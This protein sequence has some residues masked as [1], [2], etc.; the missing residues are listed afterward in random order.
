MKKFYFLVIAGILFPL[1]IQSQGRDQSDGMIPEKAPAFM[2]YADDVI[3][4]ENPAENQR[5]ACISVAFNGWLYAAHLTRV[6][7]SQAVIVYRS[8]DQ[9]GTWDLWWSL[10]FVTTVQVNA[11]DI[12]VCGNTEEDLM[13]FLAGTHYYDVSDKY[14]TWV[15]S[16]EGDQ[17]SEETQPVLMEFDYPVRDIAIVSDYKFPSAGAAPYSVGVLFPESTDVVDVLHFL[18]SADGG[19]SFTYDRTL[20]TSWFIKNVSAAYGRCNSYPSGRYFLAWDEFQYP[21]N[22]LGRIFWSYTDPGFSS[23][24]VSAVRLDIL[25]P[26]LE[27]LCKNPVISSQF[28]AY[29]NSLGN[30]TTVILFERAWEGSATDY[31]VLGYYNKESVWTNAWDFTSISNDGLNAIQPDINF[32]PAYGNF[33]VTYLDS[34]NQALPYYVQY[35]EMETPINWIPI[36]YAYNDNA[37]GLV[38]PYPKVEIN[39]VEVQT[40]HLWTREGVGGNGITMFDAEYNFVGLAE[41]PA[42]VGLQARVYPNPCTDRIKISYYL[43]GAGHVTLQISDLTGRQVM[44]LQDILAAKGLQEIE[45]STAALEQGCYQY[46]IQAAALKSQGK[47]TVLNRP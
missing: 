8:I 41:P 43:A 6:G 34:T 5:H 22:R 24:L 31:D 13:V 9:G 38:A 36:S 32:D 1:L 42:P 26:A 20:A 45:I 19:V 7:T 44:C 28:T 4:L 10:G 37:S 2:R 3:I 11:L 33:L 16:F 29:D 30:L 23:E 15:Y 39:P 18:V 21:G 46:V 17:Y 14:Y 25:S 27:D 12:V 47:F 40:A 35:L